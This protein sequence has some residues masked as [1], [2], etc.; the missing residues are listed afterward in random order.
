MP[1]ILFEK[2]GPVAKIILN[3]PDQLNAITPEMADELFPLIPKI[4]Q[5]PEIRVVLVTGSGR[6]FSSGGNLQFI[7]DHV[8]KG[9]AENKKEMIEFYS[10]F[11]SLRTIEVPTIAVING[12]AMGAGLCIAMACDLRFASADAKMGVN[13]AKIGLSSGMGCLYFLTHITGSARAADLLFTGRTI[14]AEEAYQIGLISRIFS[15]EELESKTMEVA[16]QIAQNA[17]LPLKLMKK[18]IQKAAL[19]TLEEI[20]DYE[21]DGQALS[22]GTEDLKEGIRAMQEKRVPKFVGR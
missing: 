15:S 19:S 8:Q 18:G 9:R 3:N 6:A 22:F 1:L 13:F 2:K 20:F 4:N 12:P 17:P 11:L 10:K 14:S 7:L 5:D 16:T 21:S